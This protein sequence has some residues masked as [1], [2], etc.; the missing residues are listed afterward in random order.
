MFDAWLVA[1]WAFVVWC[2]G[3]RHHSYGYAKLECWMARQR[4]KRFLRGEEA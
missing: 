1:F 2:G 3:P 4:L